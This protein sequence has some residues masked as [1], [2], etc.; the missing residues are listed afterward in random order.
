VGKVT[1]GYLGPYRLLNVV[2][3]GH[4]SQL[5]QGYDD[6]HQRMVGVKAISEK[7]SKDSEQVG[8]LRLEYH[9]GCKIAHPHVI[10]VYAFDIDR[11][12][13][14]LAMEWFSAPNLKRR[15]RTKEERDKILHLIPK[16]ALQSAEGLAQIHSIGYVHR[17]VK[18][19]NFLVSD[20]GDVKLIDFGLAQKAKRGLAK[21]LSFT[22]PKRQGTPSYM[23]PEQIRCEQL[24]ERADVYSFGCVLYEL[25][26]GNPPFTGTKLEELFQKHLKAAPPSLEVADRNLT[27]EFAQLMK[28]CLSK[29]REGRPGSMLQFLEEFRK[30]KVFRVLPRRLAANGS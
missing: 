17:D 30:L 15:V 14:Y 20:E 11:G 21:F 28:R 18:P 16:I 3:T 9:V 12:I 25:L 23:A 5:W 10:E 7:F 22:K 27:P 13:P 4:A 2:H 29:D 19:E 8:S 24:D 1:P 26:V 6:R